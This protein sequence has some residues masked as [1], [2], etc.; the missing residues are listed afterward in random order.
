MKSKKTMGGII[1]RRVAMWLA[2]LRLLDKASLG[3]E[4]PQQQ[5]QWQQQ[6]SSQTR[7]NVK[8]VTRGTMRMWGKERSRLKNLIFFLSYIFS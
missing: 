4:Q 1:R 7:P 5:Q 2:R 8:G 3:F 6:P